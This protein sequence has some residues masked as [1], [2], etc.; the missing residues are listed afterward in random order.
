MTKRAHPLVILSEALEEGEVEGPH[1]SPA[2]S[3]KVAYLGWDASAPTEERLHRRKRSQPGRSFDSAQDDKTRPPRHPERRRRKPPESKDPTGRGRLQLRTCTLAGM[4]AL[5]PGNASIA[6]GVPLQGDPSTA[7]R[8]T[9]RAHPLV[10]LSEGR[11]APDP[12]V[13]L[14][15]ALEEGGVE[16]PHRPRAP[17]TKNVHLGWDACAPTRKRLHRCKRLQPGRSFD[18]AQDDKTRPLVILSGGRE[19][20]GVEGPRRSKMP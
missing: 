19:A 3:T 2:P 11:E 5:Q 4:P 15:V 17:S 7:L 12:L 6:A 20:P 1:W 8:M 14:S 9:K 16:G 10:I 18:F 13:I